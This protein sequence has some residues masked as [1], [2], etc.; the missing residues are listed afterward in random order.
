[1]MNKNFL[2]KLKELLGDKEFVQRCSAMSFAVLFT[3]LLKNGISLDKLDENFKPEKE[4]TSFSLV[5]DKENSVYELS[6]TFNDSNIIDVERPTFADEKSFEELSIMEM[7]DYILKKYKVDYL[8]L[9]QAVT[10]YVCTGY[11]DY[12]A[13]QELQKRED[14]PEMK[15]LFNK[16]ADKKLAYVLERRNLTLDQFKVVAAYILRETG[17]LFYDEAY[18]CI[19][20][21]DNR[22]HSKKWV[23][24]V[25]YLLGQ[26]AG[27]SLYSNVLCPGQYPDPYGVYKK[28]LNVE[29]H[30]GY[31]AILD[32][33]VTE[34]S[35]TNYTSFWC[36][37]SNIGEELTTYGNS[38]FD[39]VLEDDWIE[40]PTL[41]EVTDIKVYP[42]VKSKQPDKDISVVVCL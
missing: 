10:P 16:L 4:S 31:Y 25:N 22:T 32:Y 20:T 7:Q 21:V 29:D 40:N 33:L 8:T 23:N 42:E 13:A 14:F 37:G 19:N 41:K 17:A 27:Y 24:Y 12:T 15:E 1:M 6:N 5:R 36:H 30:I 3:F 26:G 2:L 18:Y 38:Y 39:P 11:V 28:Y 35:K 9:I 34:K